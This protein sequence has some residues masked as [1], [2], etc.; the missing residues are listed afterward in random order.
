MSAG[1]NDLVAGLLSEGQIETVVPVADPG[2]Q[3]GL[4]AGDAKDEGSAGGDTPGTSSGEGLTTSSP[5]LPAIVPSEAPAPGFNIVATE[6][7]PTPT[8]VATATPVLPTP[9]PTPM[10]PTAAPSPVPPTLT[11]TPGLA[12][13]R[14]TPAPTENPAQRTTVGTAA[15][16]APPFLRWQ[17]GSEVSAQD[18]EIA[19]A[20]TQCV[21]E[22]L[23]SL[24][25]P[26]I[27]DHI[28]LNMYEDF[29]TVVET[30]SIQAGQSNSF[31]RDFWKE[32]FADSWPDWAIINLSNAAVD[33]SIQDVPLLAFH[34]ANTFT[35][36]ILYHLSE[37]PP[38]HQRA[39]S[40]KWDPTVCTWALTI[41]CASRPYQPPA[42]SSMRRSGKPRT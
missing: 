1:G 37:L 21:F 13:P 22:Y 26:E 40:L 2:A 10:E 14:P 16:E 4:V 12:T 34:I 35:R 9:R 11:A 6:S 24:G 8:L 23:D 19:A 29:E 28:T 32:R 20:T 39:K 25:L 30:Y 33:G 5:K 38:A 42:L 17:I 36:S 18:R 3:A 7:T 31:S 15:T 41:T 27:S